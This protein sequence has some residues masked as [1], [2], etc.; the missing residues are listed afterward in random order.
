MK[1]QRALEVLNFTEIP[2]SKEEVQRRYRSLAKK[3]HPDAGGSAAQFSELGAALEYVLRALELKHSYAANNTYAA[4]P[5]EDWERRRREE[6]RAR[7]RNEMLKKRAMEDRR[8]NVQA[9]WTLAI[10]AS[11]VGFYLLGL[12]LKSH[13][14]HWRISQSEVERL[15]TVVRS[16][17]P[18]HFDIRWDYDGKIFQKSIRGQSK[19]DQAWLVG[20]SGMPMLPGS[21]YIVAFNSN[22]PDYFEL[23]D[24]YLSPNTAETYYSLTKYALAEQLG[25]SEES[26]EVVCAFWA[27]LDVYGVDGVAHAFWSVTPRRKNWQHNERTWEALSKS[28][29][30]QEIVETCKGETGR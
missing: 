3:V 27:L 25:T 15:A 10:V 12:W 7:W 8:R 17:E 26:V 18:E 22:D 21:E 6:E 19:G 16:I 4:D 30:W 11:L 1:L 14:I 13:Y 2:S 24:V 5:S 9:N 23:R 28:S 29:R 20:P